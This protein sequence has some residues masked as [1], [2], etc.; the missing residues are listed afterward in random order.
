[1][2]DETPYS[3]RTGLV[4]DELIHKEV[5]REV[6]KVGPPPTRNGANGMVKWPALIGVLVVLAGLSGT[7]VLLAT[8]ADSVASENKVQKLD[9]DVADLKF[10][11]LKTVDKLDSKVQLLDYK[12]DLLL[13]AAKIPVPKKPPPE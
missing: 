6:S 1:M 3:P 10:A 5:V 9:K 13:E 11:P 2:T 12:L 8:S 4:L 7:A